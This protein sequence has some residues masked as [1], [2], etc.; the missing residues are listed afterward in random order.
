LAQSAMQ[1]ARG[2]GASQLDIPLPQFL[3]T[4]LLFW[5]WIFLRGVQCNG[6]CEWRR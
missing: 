5:C 1:L 3:F 2:D 4:T 6:L